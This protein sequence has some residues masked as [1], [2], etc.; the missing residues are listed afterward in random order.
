MALSCYTKEPNLSQNEI[1]ARQFAC[2]EPE[3]QDDDWRAHMDAIQSATIM[4]HMQMHQEACAEHIQF[5]TQQSSDEAAP[6]ESAEDERLSDSILELDTSTNRQ[7]NEHGI[8][9]KD[10]SVDYRCRILVDA[11]L[12][13]V[14]LGGPAFRERVFSRVHVALEDDLE[15]RLVQAINPRFKGLPAWRT[16]PEEVADE[17]AVEL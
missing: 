12:R 1:A 8:E 2:M 5:D 7:A 9:G 11:I 17:R 15:R 6:R 10:E 14:R 16:E 4:Q 13:V 3:E